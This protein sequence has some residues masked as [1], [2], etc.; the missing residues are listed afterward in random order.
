MMFT[1]DNLEVAKKVAKEIGIREIKAEM[2]PTDKYSELEK[3]INNKNSGKVAFVGDGINDAPV[4]ALSDIGISMGGIGSSSAIEASDMVIMTDN[5]NKIEE[6]IKV[7]KITDKIICF[8]NKNISIDFKCFWIG[9]NV[10]G[11]ICR[12]WCN[13]NYNFKYT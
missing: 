13:F 4:L 6:A 11:S 2:L 3:I 5:L 9:S 7:S 1:G 8:W 10:D 12:C